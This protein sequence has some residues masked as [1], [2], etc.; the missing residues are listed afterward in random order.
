[1]KKGFRLLL[2][3]FTAIL[4]LSGLHL[5]SQSNDETVSVFQADDTARILKAGLI[6]T[7]MNERDFTMT[8]DMQ[9]VFFTVNEGKAY[10]IVTMKKQEE[11]W[12]QPEIVSFNSA[13]H[14]IEPFVAPDGKTLFFASNRPRGAD[15]AAADFDIWKVERTA[16]GWG[17]PVNPG[18]PVNTDKN[19]FYPSVAANGNLY[20]TTHDDNIAVARR[21]DNGYQ[22]PLLLPDSINTNTGEYN[23]FI[24]PGEKYLLFSSHGWK[25]KFGRGDIFISYKKA[26]GGW[27]T[28]QC[29]DGRVNSPSIDMCPYVSPNGRLLFFS[30]RRKT[31]NFQ[32]PSGYEDFKKMALRPGNGSLDIYVVKTGMLFNE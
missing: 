13:Y 30:S 7:F 4:M 15:T 29:L 3:V 6:S 18:T 11:G 2:C 9:Q 14:D 21:M 12:S 32:Q 25:Q 20:F 5:H 19:E 1:M 31:D 27:T 23:A 17:S 10:A 8:P 26:A 16:D 28:P 22:K 24:H